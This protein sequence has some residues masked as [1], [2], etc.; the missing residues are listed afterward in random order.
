MGI[1]ASILIVARDNPIA[2]WAQIEALVACD[3][4]EDVEVVVVDD[5]SGADVQALLARLEGDVTIHRSDRA[6][7]RRAALTGAARAAA[8]DVC[9]ALGSAA[10]PRPGFVEPLVAAVR[11]GA[12]LAAPVLETGAGD[13]HG[14]RAA[15]DGSLWPLAAPGAAVDALGVDCLAARRSW[16]TDRQP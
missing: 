16:W 4:A 10:R 6:V 15:A 9:I 3:L 1:R 5:A 2:L 13:V 8:A 7:G 12:V 14:Y 11:A